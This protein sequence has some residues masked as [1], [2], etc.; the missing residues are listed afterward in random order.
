MTLT[1]SEEDRQVLN[2]MY[3]E[4]LEIKQEVLTK[5]LNSLIVSFYHSIAFAKSFE[6]FSPANVRQQG[7]I[8][9]LTRRALRFFGLDLE[10]DSRSNKKELKRYKASSSHYF[11]RSYGV[12]LVRRTLKM[13]VFPVYLFILLLVYLKKPEKNVK[14]KYNP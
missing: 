4:F 10:Q 2:E 5:C 7:L 14:N 1:L 12:R 11:T 6:D 3:V 13:M 9:I 8:T